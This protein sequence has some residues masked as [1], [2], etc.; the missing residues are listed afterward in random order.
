MFYVTFDPDQ[1]A[2]FEHIIIIGNNKMILFELF[3]QLKLGV[4]NH[5]IFLI[6]R[7]GLFS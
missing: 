6:D 4:I 3:H 1:S 7:M 2:L 5:I